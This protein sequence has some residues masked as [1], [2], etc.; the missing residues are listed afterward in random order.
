VR[1]RPLRDLR[2]LVHHLR[3]DV[4]AAGGVEDD[5]VVPVLDR[6]S[7]ALRTDF[8]S[9][10]SG[11]VEHGHADALAEYAQLLDG[12]GAL[13]VGS[14]EQ[15]TL[16]MLVAQMLRELRARGGLA[17]AL[18]PGDEH[19]RRPVLRELEPRA[20][21]PHE[22]DELLMARVDELLRR[23]DTGD[24][25]RADDALADLVREVA[26]DLEVDVS[27]EQRGADGAQ[28]LLD[29]LGSQLLLAAEEREGR[30]QT[31]GEGFEH[32]CGWGAKAIT[33]GP[34]D[35]LVSPKRSRRRRGLA[36]HRPAAGCAARRSA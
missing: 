31:L 17:R 33:L 9:T 34:R 27:L 4:Q 29:V 13:D 5:D 16:A 11:N 26:R 24:A 35:R 32:G 21:G 14:D 3:I 28:A 25:L 20:L 2:H 18:Q 7:D 19:D 36:R 8:G 22:L 1:L 6:V 12:R 15:R 10:D 23:L 30:R